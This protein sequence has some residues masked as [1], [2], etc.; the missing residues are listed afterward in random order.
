MKEGQRFSNEAAMSCRGA[1]CLGT[2]CVHREP[3]PRTQA[4]PRLRDEPLGLR[5]EHMLFFQGE[6]LEHLDEA[7]NESI[8]TTAAWID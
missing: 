6:R 8:C 7:G 3:A 5:R 1:S 2:Y 4:R